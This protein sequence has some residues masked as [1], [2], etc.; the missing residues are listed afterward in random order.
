MSNIGFR[1]ATRIGTVALVGT[2]A[3]MIPFTKSRANEIIDGAVAAQAISLTNE[4]AVAFNLPIRLGE[5][6]QIPLGLYTGE[7]L[8]STEPGISLFTEEESPL[9]LG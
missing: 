8:V 5:G 7:Q 4:L 1:I 2:A 3:K 9:T 6:D